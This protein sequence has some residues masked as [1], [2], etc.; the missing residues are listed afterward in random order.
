MEAE[1]TNGMA[2]VEGGEWLT[3]LGQ[4]AA[5]LGN[6]TPARPFKLKGGWRQRLFQPDRRKLLFQKLEGKMWCAAQKRPFLTRIDLAEKVTAF[7]EKLLLAP[8]DARVGTRMLRIVPFSFRDAVCVTEMHLGW[9]IMATASRTTRIVVPEGQTLSVR[10]SAVVAWTGLPP[11]G[12]CP[13]VKLRDLFLPRPP[14]CLALNF[15][16]PAIVWLEGA[17]Q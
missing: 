5:V 15:H 17:D 10:P 16:G 4:P 9:A 14:K 1:I 11:T 6:T 12:Y 2:Q 13:R 7:T 3:A 8:L